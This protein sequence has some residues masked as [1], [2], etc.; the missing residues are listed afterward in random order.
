MHALT[1]EAD[2]TALRPGPQS[3]GDDA[4]GAVRS[5]PIALI[6]I[7]C[8]FPG[9]IEDPRGF[10]E[11]L[12]SGTDAIGDIPPDRWHADA[13]FDPDPGTP[14]RMIVRQGG[15]LRSPIDRFDAGFFGMTPREA[16]ALDPQQ[17]L[18]LE[19]TWEAFE[20]AGL[21]PSST[22]G[23]DVGA[24]IGGFTF[25]AAT[26][27]LSDANRDLV[28]GSTPTGVS[29]TMLAARLSYA[30]DWRGP[31]LTM[32]TACSSSLVAFHQ[33]CAALARGECDLAV[34]GGVN[35]MTN[36]VTTILMSKGQFL[37]PDARSRSF[38]HRANGYARGE[39]AGIVLLKPLAAAERDG[40]HIYAVVRGSAVN[41][42]G[43]T[44]G[45]TVPN[46]EAQRAV[47]RQAC[48]VAGI[49]PASVGYY[50]AHG[51]GTP[52]GDPIEA[53]AIGDVLD[54]SERTHWIG[55]VKSNIGHTE[56]AAGVAGVIKASLCLERGVI[57]PNLHFERPNP[58]IPFDRLPL[59]VPTEM[60]PFPDHGGPRRAGVNS[61]GFGGTNA[62][63][64]LEQASRGPSTTRQETDDGSPR[65][66]VLS[67]RSQEALRALVDAYAAMLE[68][69]EAPALSRVC[70]AAARQREHHPLRTFV[71][72][73]D[74]AEAAKELRRLDVAPR[75]A[76]RG[77]AAFVYTGMGPQWWG[78]GRE[79]L[80]EEPRFA[81]VVAECDEILAR[82]GLSIAEELMREEAESRLTRTLYAQ[83]ANFVVQV[84]LTALW[85]DRGIVPTVIVGHSVGEVAAA[86]A[87][88][89]YSL[90]DA[91]TI[92]FHRANLQARLA[93]RGTMA[94]V[95]VPADTARS[96][97]IDG[98]DVAAIN[99]ASATTLSGDPDAMSVVTERLEASGATVR[100]LRVE[101]AY[102]SH[103]M[104][105]IREPLLT[106]LR[107]I[108][109]GAARIPLLSTVTGEHVTG[110][111]LDAEYWWR[112]VRQPVLFAAALR[113]LLTS[114]PGIIL[115]IGPHP[116]LASAIDEA[117]AERGD[118]LVRLA[119]QR[120]D[121]PQR[122]HL[123]ETLGNMYAAGAEPDWER[124]HPGPREHL[125]LP[126]YPWQREHHWVESAESRTAR[127]GAGGPRL[128][129]RP[130]P[131]ATP[132]RDVELSAAEFPYLAD[133]RIGRT[134]IFPGSGYLEAALAM[135]SG[136][137]PCCS[138]E[139]VI[140][141]RPLAL[142]P[143]TLATLRIGYDPVRRLVTLH[144]RGQGD[145]ATWTLHAQMRHPDLARPRSPR[146][147]TEGP[148]DLTRSLPEYGHDE[149]YALLDGSDLSYGPAFRAVDRLWCRE[150][151][152]EVFAELR[153]DTVDPEG[154]R[155]HPALLDAALQ[156]MIAGALQLA[157][158]VQAATYVPARI[159]ELRFFRSPG[160]R[161]WLHGRDRRS[162]VA[163][164]LE[165][166]LTL[167]TDDGEVVAEVIGL[168]AQRLAEDGSQ[169]RTRP[170]ETYYEHLWRP[171]TL[172]ATGGAEG[173]WIVVG[174]ST[175]GEGL[176]HGLSE[177]GG[178]VLRAEP[179]EED[180][181]ERVVAGV[182]GTSGGSPCRGVVYVHD[183][184]DDPTA[185]DTQV[186]SSVATPLRLVQALPAVAVPLFLITSGAQSVDAGDATTDPFAA[187]LWG[188]G[189][190]VDAERP[191][192]RCRLIDVDSGACGG[193]GRV[194]ESVLD[195][196]AHDGLEEVALRGGTRYVRRLERAGARSPMHHVSTR[197]DATPVRLRVS[198]PG[199]DGLR[200][201]AGARRAPGPAE[202]EI[203]V[204]YVG[205]NFKDVL[206]AT[207][208]MSPEA[209]EGS[210]SQETLGLECSG[211]V[212]RVGEA[213][214]DL[215]PGDEVFAHGRDL[216]A[217]HV[218]LD[219]V[220]V[221]KK[222][223]A[224]SLAQAASLLP[225]VTA[226]L[227]LV[228]L[229]GVRKGDRVLIHSASGGVGLAAV[230]IATRLGAEVYA[231]AGSEERREFLRRE[232]VAGVSDSRSTSFAD[233]ILRWTGGA[234]VDVVINALAGEMLHKSVGLLRPFGR[235]VELG[236]ADI[237]ADHP[238][239][240]APFHRALS[241]HAFDYDRMMLLEPELVR[242][243]MR[244]LADLYEKE[245]FAPL[246]VTEVPAGEVDVAFRM[247]ARRDHIGKI[248]VRVAG[249]PVTVPAST[250]QD[251]PIRPD[252][253]YLITGG[254]G[255][256]G[257]TVARWLADR[258]AR[259]LVLLGRH[260]LA[261][262]EAEQVVTE[263]TG[264]GVE[265]RVQQA[266]VADGDLMKRVLGRI[267]AEMPPIRGI[268][269]A[270]AD[271]DDVVLSETDATR[272]ITATKPKADGAW[273]LH[274]ETQAESLDFFVL[275]S[276]VAAQ[277]GA[278]AAGAYATAN[279]FLNALARYRH[280]RGLPAISVGW[281]MI[282]EV[283]V[284]VSRN[285][286]VGD[287]LRRNGHI[288]M[289]PE[290]L[291]TELETL[292]RTRPVEVSVADIDW[293][294]WA[295]ANPQLAPL[296]RY[297]ALVPAGALD[298]DG[299][300]SASQRLRDA[301]PEER[302]SLLPA[303]VT[304]LLQ[305]ITGLSAEQLDDQQAVDIDSLVA[306]ELRVLLR[307]N[308]GVSVPAMKLQRNLTVAGLV[309]LLAEELD[310][311]PASTPRPPAGIT[312]H[313]FLSSDGLTIYGHLSLPAGPGPHPAVV[314]CTAGEGGALDD[315][316][317]YAHLS[318]HAPLRA[319]G[320]AVF[321]VDHR[322]APGHGADYSARAEM[323]GRDVDDIM[324]AARHL[325]E[326]PEI[327]ATRL[328]IV[329]TSRGAYSALLALSRGPSLWHRSVLI[330]GLY[331]PALLVAAERSRPG[332]LLPAR[333]QAEP[334][335]VETY[336]AA[337][338][339]RPMS[340]LG[341]VTAPLL[342]VH[343]DA[344]EVVP[345]TQAVRLADR[346]HELD[347][348]AR[349]ITVPGL[350]H[351][352]DHADEVWAGLWPQI[353]EFL[354]EGR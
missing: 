304:P 348:P 174:S 38:D 345:L 203:E 269:H 248:V 215:R 337:P 349:L 157:G 137:E 178:T 127:L 189:R 208:L 273:H 227:S 73:G 192:L 131:A 296:P 43:R 22:A 113:R 53:T 154:Y 285:G 181:L 123:L 210:L 211:T 270:A 312:T 143:S 219:A 346:A 291:V 232:G 125:D 151:T 14:G 221:V 188:F 321:T 81:Q 236:K 276:S 84:G 74:P 71:V 156:A 176:A 140:F 85:R 135:F 224:L 141:H 108:R 343:G 245:T 109:P 76:A 287:V 293:R 30:F 199:V 122:R 116:V 64:I 69:P 333:A 195:E 332:A 320:F 28:S 280:A 121:R 334:G 63:V 198:E 119:S 173:T 267:R 104:D 244:E 246:P 37:S 303:L 240:L 329:G 179:G 13:F 225:A 305:E 2:V 146:P 39:G 295:R 91:L 60:V 148:A 118:D 52:V 315:A 253:T 292:L 144:S 80:R 316:G 279:E 67:A 20:D 255:G 166:D 184:A 308:L 16:A 44:P 347:V 102:H 130:V 149:V 48:R 302:L 322:G 330:M 251:S 261:T 217:S 216:F 264:E 126:R 9:G 259:H 96:F 230:R 114:A 35:V 169:Q 120:R 202:V 247:M 90:E 168:R 88:G 78:M 12:A 175:M 89:V 77:G 313:D 218:T 150:E 4:D 111:E 205:L 101:V 160:R 17:R 164:R 97:L 180:W 132:T 46:A 197:T 242:D 124:V 165:C 100:A 6:G 341:A 36:P 66:L 183:P 335:D 324:A 281:G 339:R 311:P 129:G 18:L 134:V 252:A 209:M 213:V 243:C 258:G 289:P 214:T 191:E 15:F 262:P 196:L 257:R 26:L 79:L 268:V 254:L 204:A 231:T 288:G 325:A 158:G 338:Q 323:G 299:H 25:D 344:D 250:I 93:G 200:F 328:S 117:L 50:E 112:N 271:F 115:E 277:I 185:D 260:G 170:E 212:V 58:S 99:S 256:L 106:A 171:E 172:D 82:F 95:D 86:Y 318:E 284:A 136:D 33:A 163:G 298:D 354:K 226:Y 47:I 206:K 187:A 282:D 24:Y 194:A 307:N 68:A 5:A 133:H 167:I 87:A 45:I 331:D 147:R 353:T 222:P 336:F 62:H 162:M 274:Q 153:V 55:S 65:L 98:V 1:H 8:R 51:T 139:D 235:F 263:L 249:E 326:L 290:R 61:F 42:D 229:A 59:R 103:Q 94:A 319:A 105:E 27:Q 32:D 201:A 237:A 193:A 83:V 145:D 207:G 72:A 301:T 340:R 142:Q 327:D 34:A 297:S 309:G 351:D 342:I 49:H 283:G 314:V 41:Q 31:S 40:D 92:G 294:R 107:G 19:V 220:R 310:R 300:A 177:R 75:R 278:A 155:L 182:S 241:F 317:N 275:F 286:A 159:A 29:M 7:G 128:A 234:G 138:L 233:D 186:C 3:A 56:A 190:V 350:G 228:R 110:T 238:L 272:L 239:G 161:L 23:A 70:R 265:V 306:V 352:S 21:P 223:A 266:D 54:G 57:P 11:L 10:W 152:G